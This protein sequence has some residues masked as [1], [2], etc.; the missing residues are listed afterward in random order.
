MALF[1][2]TIVSQLGPIYY[3]DR[4]LVQLSI[5]SQFGSYLL[6]ISLSQFGFSLVGSPNDYFCNDLPFMAFAIFY[7]Y[8]L[9]FMAFNHTIL[10]AIFVTY[11]IRHLFH[12]YL[13]LISFCAFISKR[14]GSVLN[15]YCETTSYLLDSDKDKGS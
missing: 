13:L 8:E 10:Y 2:I 6:L 4:K 11:H 12:S 9:P 15:Y 7:V 3:C 5:M 14:R 1:I